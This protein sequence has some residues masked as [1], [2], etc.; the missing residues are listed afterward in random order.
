LPRAVRVRPPLA[1]DPTAYAQSGGS[2]RDWLIQ[3]TACVYDTRH[4]RAQ[5]M[6]TRAGHRLVS[7]Q[8]NS[9]DTEGRGHASDRKEVGNGAAVVRDS[10]LT[11]S[12]GHLAS[13]N[14]QEGRRESRAW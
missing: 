13:R 14:S 8:N 4:K 3:A 6:P 7:C 11:W 5:E 12:S 1:K 9:S 2:V 10:S